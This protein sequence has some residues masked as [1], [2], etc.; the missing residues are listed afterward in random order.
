[1]LGMK[2]LLELA[3][4]GT[5]KTLH[6]MAVAYFEAGDLEGALTWAERSGI[7]AHTFLK[8]LDP[9]HQNLGLWRVPTPTGDVPLALPPT[10]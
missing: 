10:F 1:M 5:H 2:D 4:E 3:K 6:E 9:H 8:D 7:L